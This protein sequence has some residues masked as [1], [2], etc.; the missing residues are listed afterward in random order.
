VS[1]EDLFNEYNKGKA[2]AM[3]VMNEFYAADVVFHSGTGENVRGLNEYKKHNSEL[4]D[5]FPD[6]HWTVEDM[7]IEGS[8]KAM[9]FTLTCTHKGAFRGIPPTNK[10]VTIQAISISQSDAGGKII[11]EWHMYDTLGLMQ[12]LGVI[13]KP[14]KGK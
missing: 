14:E 12:K 8:K 13:P 9:R 1:T 4:Y 10:K 6:I 3:T 11:E 2:A 5:A 7:I